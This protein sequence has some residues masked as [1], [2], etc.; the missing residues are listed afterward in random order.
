[1]LVSEFTDN[2][3]LIV[4]RILKNVALLLKILFVISVLK[5]KINILWKKKINKFK[6]I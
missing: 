6:F 2:I 3:L 5:P 4:D 1:M